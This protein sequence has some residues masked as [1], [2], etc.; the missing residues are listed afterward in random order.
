[1]IAVPNRPRHP[2]TVA[3]VVLRALEAK[4]PRTHYHVG[5]DI[6]GLRILKALTPTWLLDRILARAVDALKPVN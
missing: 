4:W 2:K 5:L 6:I 3:R 1:M